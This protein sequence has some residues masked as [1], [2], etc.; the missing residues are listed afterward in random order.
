MDVICIS[1]TLESGIGVGQEI[2]I[3]PDKFGK[4]NKHKCLE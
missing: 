4:K 3:G 2:N 1:F